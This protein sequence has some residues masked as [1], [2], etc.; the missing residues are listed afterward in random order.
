MS[1]ADP[2]LEE[3]LDPSVFMLHPN[4]SPFPMDPKEFCRNFPDIP[5][6]T[7]SKAKIP[8]FYLL[9]KNELFDRRFK[10]S[11]V[12]TQHIV[13]GEVIKASTHDTGSYSHFAA[14]KMSM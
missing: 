3:N 14:A 13:K 7:T 11:V 12:W 2:S 9:N 10:K 6:E 4:K 8:V 1:V 5:L